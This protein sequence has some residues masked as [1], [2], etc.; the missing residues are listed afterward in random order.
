ML[1]DYLIE[2]Y[3]QSAGTG[4]IELE[5]CCISLLLPNGDIFSS[6]SAWFVTSW[7]KNQVRLCTQRLGELPGDIFSMETAVVIKQLK[8]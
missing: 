5:S 6:Q 2:C 4:S 1:Q 8:L 3:S 7:K